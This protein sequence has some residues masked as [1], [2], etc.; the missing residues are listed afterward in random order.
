M[1]WRNR[2]WVAI[3]GTITILGLIDIPEQFD[4]W[5]ELMADLSLTVEFGSWLLISVGI[6]I[7][8]LGGGRPLRLLLM[9][10]WSQIR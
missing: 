2:I 4:K 3:G 9:E 7:I 10:S 1:L 8:F 6:L 5:H